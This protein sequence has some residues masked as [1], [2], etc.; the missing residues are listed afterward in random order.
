[1]ASLLT[2]FC[3]WTTNQAVWACKKIKPHISYAHELTHFIISS[4]LSSRTVSD[5]VDRELHRFENVIMKA[6]VCMSNHVVPDGFS[7]AALLII[8]FAIT[9]ALFY[10]KETNKHQ[11]FFLFSN[12]KVSFVPTL[13]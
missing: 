10:S 1:M 2:L 6:V 5:K 11:P 3:S 7:N 8:F 13:Q 4:V 9:S 12:I